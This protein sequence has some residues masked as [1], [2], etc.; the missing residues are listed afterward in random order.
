[1][2]VEAPLDSD[3]IGKGERMGAQRNGEPMGEREI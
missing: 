1:V 2:E 3:G